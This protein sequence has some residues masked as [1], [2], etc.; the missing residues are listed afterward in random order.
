MDLPLISIVLCTYNG[1]DFLEKQ[2][3]SIYAQSYPNL[4]IILSDDASSDATKNILEKY[5]NHPATIINFNKKNIGF[6]KN[7]EYGA[8]LSTGEYIAFCDQDDIWMP[9]KI[10][11]LY[12]AIGNHSLVY[13]DSRLIDENENALHK[14]LSDFRKLQNIYTSKGFAFFNAVSGHTMMAK[15]EILAYSLPTPAGYYHDWWFALQAT[16]L[17]GVKFLDEKLTLYR[18]H[19]KNVTENI[20][21]KK[22]GSRTFSKRY[23]VFLHELK[24]IEI[25]ANNRI[26]KEKCFY[27]KLHSLFILKKTQYYVWPLFWFLLKNR[28]DIFMFSKKKYTS[29]FF[30]IR[31]YARGERTN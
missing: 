28:K 2:L 13:S 22:L 14:N 25:L 24:W 3:Q 21:V 9:Q 19:D 20:I 27:N 11:K 1:A 4:E 31:K 6:A 30:E 26:E 15:R 5:K 10:E 18:Q 16:N 23:E 29:Q 17:N 12:A 8:T 7:F